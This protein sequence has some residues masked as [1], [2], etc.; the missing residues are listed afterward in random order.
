[1]NRNMKLEISNSYDEL[2]SLHSAEM[3]DCSSGRA[4][5]IQSPT[6]SQ[7][8]PITMQIGIQTL[9]DEFN[10]IREKKNFFCNT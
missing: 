8:S 3:T 9:K 5:S 6:D 10:I 4:G 1:M 2:C 7:E